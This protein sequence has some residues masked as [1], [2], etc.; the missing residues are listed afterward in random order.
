MADKQPQEQSHEVPE[1][2]LDNGYSQPGDSR[3][4]TKQEPKLNEPGADFDH[5]KD[6]LADNPDL[7]LDNTPAGQAL[8][9]SNGDGMTTVEKPIET[10]GKK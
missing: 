5:L 10:D 9:H 7:P 2:K 6:T 1:Q 4:A 8:G 3:E